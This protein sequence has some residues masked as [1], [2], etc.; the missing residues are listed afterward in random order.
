M[1]RFECD[2]LEGCH[3]AIM[4]ALEASNLEQTPGYGLDAHCESART[5]I[6]A[7]CGTS[8]A[9]VHFITG[10]TLANLTVISSILRPHQ[11]VIAADEGHV[12]V[13]ETGA[14]EAT[15]H[16]VLTLPSHDGKISADA[17]RAYCADNFESEVH[18]HIVEAGMVY[19]SQPTECGT[20]YSRAEL[21][22]IADV[23]REFGLPL[24]V[25]GAR[26][27]CAL[28]SPAGDVTLP[29]LAAAASVFTIGGTKCGALFGEAVV[30]TDRALARSF[31]SIMKQR[32]AL[33]AKGRLL[34]IQF[35]TLFTDGLYE[36]ISR[37]SVERAL[38]IRATFNE[39]GIE[40][41]G[42]SMTNQQFPILTR[43]QA[44]TFTSDFTFERWC[45][46]DDGREVVRFCTSWATT[47]E[48]EAALIAAIR[49]L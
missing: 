26:L 45:R 16:K 38:R 49:R 37:E 19:I 30:I 13:H 8:D 41:F 32:G 33:L 47:D 7:A 3:P 15:G 5:K 22:A 6:R 20:L 39:K 35:E 21:D 24:F 18:E 34:G 4:R 31:R 17:I 46:L 43:A 27:G 12:A 44:E 1:Y 28:T 29:Q 11:G 10:G 9:D 42:S 40:M 23:C 48:A 14:I 2:Y 25:D 36:R